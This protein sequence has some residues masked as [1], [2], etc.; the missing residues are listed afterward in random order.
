MLL[1]DLIFLSSAKITP[2]RGDLFNI[3]LLRLPSSSFFFSWFLCEPHF[4][5]HLIFKFAYHNLYIG[6]P[7]SLPFLEGKHIFELY[8][9]QPYVLN[10]VF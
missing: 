1:M 8:G 6:D 4:D 10:L 5:I 3:H 2:E 9:L 7:T